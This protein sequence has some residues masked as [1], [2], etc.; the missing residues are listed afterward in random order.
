MRHALV[1][2][3]A[4]TVSSALAAGARTT[5]TFDQ[6]APGKPPA[7]FSF[8]HTGGIGRPGRWVVEAIKDAPSGGRALGQ[9]DTD[10]TDGRYA[11]AVADQPSPKDLR[12]SVKCK[13]A[14][15]TV[16]RACG[17]VFRYR[18]ENN[19]YLAR[20]NALEDNVRLY[21][22]RNGKRTQLAS[23]DGKVAANAWQTIEVE[24]KGNL[25]RVS[26]SGKRVIEATDATFAEAGKVG[27]WTKADSVTYFDDLSVTSL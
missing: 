4:L 21:H 22:V 13:P 23:W 10:Q 3:G 11:M 5:W 8:R 6:D 15:G 16:D 12:L 1:V 20:A 25:L 18:D 26:W 27:L 24:A 14:A 17:L 2:V 19:Y 9:I 7:G